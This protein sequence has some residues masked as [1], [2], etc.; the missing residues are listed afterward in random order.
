MSFVGG[1]LCFVIV[2]Y[3]VVRLVLYVVLFMVL[4][5]CLLVFVCSLDVCRVALLFLILCCKMYC[6]VCVFPSYVNLRIRFSQP[7]P[8]VFFSEH[9]PTS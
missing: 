6:R 8:A 1:L 4:F 7:I 3:C 5:V 9:Y 2:C